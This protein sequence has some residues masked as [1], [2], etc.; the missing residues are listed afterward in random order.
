MSNKKLGGNYL[1]VENNK[2]Y[3]DL[4]ESRLGKLSEE[5]AKET[6]G[7]SCVENE[8]IETKVM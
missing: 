1:G 2:E 5:M 8:D 7:K 3:C 4:A 6:S